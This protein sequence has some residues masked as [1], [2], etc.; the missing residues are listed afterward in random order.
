MNTKR[1]Q[2]APV[3]AKTSRVTF[4]DIE[5]LANVFSLVAY[6]PPAKGALAEIEV[7][8]LVDDLAIR[9]QIDRDALNNV[10]RSGN[11]GLPEYQIAFHDLHDQ[12]ANIRLA[13]IIGLSD[14]DQVCHSTE[15]SSYPADLRPVCDTDAHFDPA[16]HA[17]IAGYNSKNYDT[18][19]IALYFADLFAPMETHRNR[20]GLAQKEVQEVRQSFVR[21]TSDVDRQR[22]TSD[23]A[24][25]NIRLDALLKTTTAFK[26][27]TAAS[28]RVHNDK[29][30]SDEHIKYMP[31]ALGWSSPAA[32]LRRSM[33]NSGR[34]LDVALLNELQYKV[35]LKRLLGM[36]GYQIKE[37]DQLKNNTTIQTLAQLYELLSYNVADCLGLGQLFEHDTYSSNFD[38]KAALLAKYSECRFAA[39]GSIR[40]DRLT[41]D[42]TSAKFVGRILAPNGPL[43]D[44]ETVSFM[45]P[46]EEV[47]KETGQTR[48][49]VLDECVKFFENDVAPDRAFNAA[50][51]SAYADF[52]KIVNYYKGIE[53]KNFN[54]SEEYGNDFSRGLRAHALKTMP[55]APGNIPY[56]YADGT[57]SSC[58]ATFSTGGIHGA[59]AN[60][61]VFEQQL[62]EHNNSVS[63]L[64]AA[65]Q[66]FPDAK[67]FVAAAKNQY[68]SLQLPDG[69]WVD[70]RLVLLGSDS[71]KVKYRKP[72]KTGLKPSDPIV[73]AD[74]SD[75][76]N[77]AYAAQLAD[78]AEQAKNRIQAEQIARAQEQ[79]PDPADLLAQQQPKESELNVLLV[80]GSVLEGKVVLAKT[81]ANSATYRTE[82]SKKTPQLFELKDDG[83]NKLDAK[84]T[85]TSAG[86][87]IHEDFTSY[88]PNLLRNMRAFYNPD[89][90][91]DRYADIFFDKERYG[92]EM[93]AAGISTE[94]R[95]R[96]NTLR[97]GTKLILNSASGAGD[98]QHKNPIRM[99]NQI[100]SM[101]IIGQ[102]LTW[103]IGEAQT[104]AGAR[105]ISTNTDGL[106]SV[107]GG[108][109]GFNAEVNNRVLEEQSAAIGI[110]IEPEPLFLIS[111]DSNNRLE[112]KAPAEGQTVADSKVIAAGGGTLACFE[113]P[114][115][116][117][118]LAHPAIIDHGLA[119][120][121]QITAARG[122]AALSEAFDYELGHQII[123]EALD[124][125]N[126]IQTAMF[127]QN[128]VNA[129]RGSITYPFAADPITD[130]SATRIVDVPRDP[131]DL[132]K[133]G[134]SATKPV[135][136]TNPDA[137]Q[138]PRPLQMNNRMF[139][140]KPGTP[141]AVGLHMAAAP[142][143]N[144]LS[145]LKRETDGLAKTQRDAIALGILSSHGWA[146]DRF[147]AAGTDLSLIPEDRD[148]SIRRIN[149]IDPTWSIV[150]NNNDLHAMDPAQLI[151]LLQSLDLP[152]YT[153]MLDDTFTNNWKNA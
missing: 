59:E 135:E 56:F 20:I 62:A 75:P 104:L 126:P 82:L 125:T 92:R 37:S 38:L 29:L 95:I 123:S 60:L 42:T 79:L 97:N 45:Y 111:K 137:L 44:I 19:M 14:A 91:A 30:F 146:P 106:Y 65:Q 57:P 16:I 109:N 35:S 22:I 72:K 85:R 110:E 117:K 153:K 112:I 25:S 53:G 76:N 96:L 86:L 152:V 21:A 63:M 15:K 141:G 12:M 74:S 9:G 24:D 28:M 77:P 113:G 128:M 36:L 84:F 39:N 89:L 50:Q 131:H 143:V 144:A 52:M 67:D 54:D 132:G 134:D 98:A 114:N 145:K 81:S 17:Q 5:A 102:L 27:L 32:K 18:S 2:R 115:P 3:T 71:A 48:V 138:N 49:N 8:Y 116:T 23:L 127:F 105:I 94:E 151:E 70:K 73:P 139:I 107:I 120:Y 140:V 46:H 87:V 119:R 41:I 66:L 51:A 69:S 100:I 33:L 118:A 10:I 83:S 99:N 124:L 121:L 122:E 34:H 64:Q 26:P 148:V 149:G 103:R 133:E 55:K 47:A 147:S 129:S 93:K 11:P 43:K 78:E 1:T 40:R 7:F 31:G 108:T 4:Y 90:G 58:F 130:Q 136:E 61:D 150:I 80:D 68:N 142:K 6:T 88:Y 101:R 13:E